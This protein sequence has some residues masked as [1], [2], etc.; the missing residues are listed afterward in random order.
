MAEKI[1]QFRGRYHFLSNFYPA[2]VW[3]EKQSYQSVEH[4]WQA[5]QCA[6]PRQRAWI[7]D[8][9]SPRAA[10]ER[11]QS[12]TQ[13]DDWDSVHVDVLRQLTR[14]KF[15]HH[16]RLRAALV[17]TGHALLIDGTDTNTLGLIL[18]EVRM[19]AQQELN[20]QALKHQDAVPVTA[21]PSAHEALLLL[22]ADLL[23]AGIYLTLQDG[24][25]LAGPTRLVHQHRSLL[26]GLRTHKKT[27]QMLLEDSLAYQLFGTNQDD[28]RFE[29]EACHECKQTVHVVTPPRRLE[30]HR[31]KDNTAVCPGSD[32]AQQACAAELVAAFLDD[33]A[34]PR[35]MAVLTWT[36]FEGAFS[37]WS[38][39]R[40]WLRPPKPYLMAELDKR[41]E[42]MGTDEQRP[43]WQGLTLTQEQW[44]GED[45]V[46]PPAQE[47]VPEKAQEREPAQ[48][49]V[50][51]GKLTLRA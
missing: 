11:G 44:F 50:K 29:T 49:V 48:A 18:M 6:D 8:A 16:P 10:R 41:F 4:A 2:Q 21:A 38:L 24:K 27:L 19:E 31:T 1:T 7:R 34:V 3:Y 42:R 39:E 32:R 28:K 15:H 45:E 47:R 25:M 30:V 23:A 37:T 36:S 20:W 40:G 5:A 43:M 13:R 26:E 22:C 35:R 33:R 12:V 51:D 46:R 14:Q 9:P 17:D